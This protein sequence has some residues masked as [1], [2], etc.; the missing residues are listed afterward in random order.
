MNGIHDVG[1]MDGFG[2]LDTDENTIDTIGYYDQWEGLVHS[3]FVGTLGSRVHNM[4]EF[5]HAVERM[6]PDHYLTARYYDR[7]LIAVQTLLV[8]KGVVSP[9]E[10]RDRV[11]EFSNTEDVSLP[12]QTNPMLIDELLAGVTEGY[13]SRRETQEPSF[14]VGDKVRVRNMNPKGHTRCPE[15]VRRAEGIIREDRGTH[16]LPD[17]HAHGGDVAEPMYN[18]EFSLDEIW[19]DTGSK[20]NNIRIE[21]WESYLEE[22][23]NE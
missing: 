6:K 22:V 18:V 23:K 14:S 5:R 13:S 17:S 16:T 3:A 7:W 8:E 15:Y 12:R 1:G 2:D 21:L 9:D 11:E 4:D 20:D 19:G 10:L